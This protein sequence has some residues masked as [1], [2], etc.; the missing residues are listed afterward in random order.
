MVDKDFIR[1]LKKNKTI[2]CPTI[3]VHNRYGD[4]FGQR[5]QFS[6]HEL[7]T[8]DP[9]QLGSLFN[10]KHT[11][12]K[13]LA[14]FYKEYADSDRFIKQSKKDTETIKTNLKLLSD[15]GVTIATGTDAGNIGTLHASSYLEEMKEMKASG[16]SNWD[17]LTAS[18][19]NGAKV[20]S[21]EDEFGSVEVGK[22]ANLILLNANPVDSLENITTIYRVINKG[23]ELFP[24]KILPDSPEDLVQQQ[25]NAYNQRNID[26]FLE[27][28][29]DDVEIYYHPD[30]LSM[31]GKEAMR[32][33]YS[34]MFQ[35]IPA[36]HCE[37][38]NRIVQGNV[39]IDH[40]NVSFGDSSIK[41]IAMYTIEGGKIQK[42]YFLK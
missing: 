31:K 24:N 12:R 29:A 10:L 40:E 9:Y 19:I 16:M 27:P 23:K 8:S 2:L 11:S 6:N 15:A 39:V 34:G 18:T 26:A 22:K 17:I 33:T 41:A 32:K 7:R 14:K 21:Q 42:V 5:H 35:T 37:L 30:K 36:L 1:L 25:L 28:Y 3:I 38:K 13:R 4:T 20:L